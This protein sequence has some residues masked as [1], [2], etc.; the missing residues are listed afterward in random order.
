MSSGTRVRRQQPASQ[1]PRKMRCGTD[2]Q[3]QSETMMQREGTSCCQLPCTLR[4]LLVQ[5]LPA[6]QR[7]TSMLGA[8][9][10]LRRPTVQLRRTHR[11]ERPAENLVRNTPAR[12]MGTPRPTVGRT[13]IATR[14]RHAQHLTLPR[15]R[16][17]QRQRQQRSLPVTVHSWP[18]RQPAPP[19]SSHP[20]SHRARPQQCDHGSP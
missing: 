6:R 16:A 3:Q 2:R 14:R 8:S 18:A 11:Q 1:S 9:T 12:S 5:P 17:L 19:P 20:N 4:V 10:D 13:P 15:L 7:Q